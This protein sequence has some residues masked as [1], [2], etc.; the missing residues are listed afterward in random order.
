GYGA[1]D[2]RR[3]SPEPKLVGSARRNSP[4]PK[5]SGRGLWCEWDTWPGARSLTGKPVR[6]R[7]AL[8]REPGCRLCQDVA[9][10]TQAMV[11]TSKAPQFL[12][13]GG[14]L[15]PSGN[16]LGG[17]LELTRQLLGRASRSHQIDHLSPEL[18]RISGSVTRHHTPQ[19]STSRVS[20]KPGQ[21]NMLKAKGDNCSVSRPR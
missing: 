2:R 20:T 13:L 10:L 14:L 15:H 21:P 4:R 1:S 5:P 11:L 18:R 3:R 12:P 6:A 16:R 17:R 8:P 7:L 19:K 9:L